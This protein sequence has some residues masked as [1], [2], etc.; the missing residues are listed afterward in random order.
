MVFFVKHCSDLN[1]WWYECCSEISLVVNGRYPEEMLSH[2]FSSEVSFSW[3]NCRISYA[4]VQASRTPQKISNWPIRKGVDGD[5]FCWVPPTKIDMSLWKEHFIF[6]TSIFRG[7]VCFSGGFPGQVA[8][9]VENCR[10]RPTDSCGT[11]RPQG[12]VCGLRLHE[13]NSLRSFEF[14]DGFYI[15]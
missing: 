12:G 15:Y 7:Y 11:K 5:L 2:H 10:P 8:L 9:T 4:P 1:F 6:Q 13:W 3:S 14:S